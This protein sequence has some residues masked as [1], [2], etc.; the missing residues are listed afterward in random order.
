MVQV[1]RV[2]GEESLKTSLIESEFVELDG[3]SFL[4]VIS[5]LCLGVHN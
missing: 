3:Y 4:F 1:E 2:S 5:N